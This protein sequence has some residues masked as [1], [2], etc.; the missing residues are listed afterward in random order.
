MNTLKNCY[1][2]YFHQHNMIIKEKT[3]KKKKSLFE[4]IHDT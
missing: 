2:H 3:K 4:L 1:I